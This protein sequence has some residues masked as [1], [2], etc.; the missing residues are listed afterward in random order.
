MANLIPDGE[1]YIY[2]AANTSRA[3][4]ISGSALNKQNVK[5]QVWTSLKNN[6]QAFQV[7]NT[8]ENVISLTS[9]LFGNRVGPVAGTSGSAIKL[10]ATGTSVP[11]SAT[12]TVEA[13]GSNVT[14]GGKSYPSYK[15]S[16]NGLN[17]YASNS[18]GAAAVLSSSTTTAAQWAF[19]PITQ[20]EDGGLFEI[21]PY[22]DKRMALDVQDFS[23]ING[24]NVQIWLAD[25][26]NNQKFVITKEATDSYSIRDVNSGK[27]VDV[28]AATAKNGTNVQ[29]FDD[30]YTRAQRWKVF[31]YDSITFEGKRCL[32]ASFGSYV[33][34]NGNTY[35][36]DVTA[37]SNKLNNNVQI[38]DTNHTDA[39]KFV[40]V[41]TEAEDTHMPTPHTIGVANSANG[42]RRVYGYTAEDLRATW[43]C[44][45]AWCAEGS[46]N[47]Y[48]MRTR[49]RHMA[50][51]TS[52][53]RSWS[54]W[55]AWYIPTV[56]SDFT[57]VC[58]TEPDKFGTY[59]WTDS[60]HQ[61][62]EIQV[63]CIGE[64]E[65][66]LLHSKTATQAVDIYRKPDVTISTITWSPHGLNVGFGTDYVYG[67][68]YVTIDA[69]TAGGKNILTAP[70]TIEANASTG[71]GV[72]PREN[73]TGW[74]SN[75]ASVSLS[76]HVGYDQQKTCDGS[77]AATKAITYDGGTVNVEPDI[78]HDGMHVYA[79]VPHLGT[80][81]MWVQHANTI[82][83]CNAQ[84]TEAHGG[85]T[86]T[87][88]EVL[89]PTNGD[90]FN[91]FTEAR[92][93]DGTQWGTDIST[94]RFRHM[95]YAW[96]IGDK[97]VYLSKFL[98]EMGRTQETYS[99]TYQADNLD[100][101]E[102]SSVSFA[103]TSTG[104][105]T[106]TGV[107]VHDGTDTDTADD[108]K[109]LIG[110]HAVYRDIAGGVYD[111]AVTSVDITRGTKYDEITVSM[112]QE[113]V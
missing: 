67:T 23:S 47:H 93:E 36:M 20:I 3:L 46:T 61:Q 6:A 75:G 74:L 19:V 81:R 109:A 108:F 16:Y 29:I 95:A 10:N 100:D 76:Y 9:R 87:K 44:S 104:T 52:S 84:G 86:C 51:N 113:T 25:H 111:V 5:V 62:V 32:V 63:R 12:F 22:F 1:Y 89:Y 65:L 30:N 2:H 97:T 35:M 96:T 49:S 34:G 48:E 7:R 66:S 101:R 33:A 71:S 42:A 39:Q 94:V 60:K 55:D 85:R 99:A 14:I 91:L 103:T 110:K 57:R 37:Q 15:L 90:D 80:E 38:W 112:I 13:T 41:P 83:E 70:T 56:T 31:E 54:N 11:A 68:T 59:A 102:W 64:D 69:I 21:R 73:L 40:L 50:P 27:Y 26:T 58:D 107:I 92:N 79:Y 43:S 105:H 4:D 17:V 72:I 45:A 88:F 8:S 53:W 106:A 28:Y 77:Q 18:N 82:V 24:A 98:G 78:V